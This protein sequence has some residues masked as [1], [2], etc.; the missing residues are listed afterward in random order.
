[1]RVFLVEDSEAVRE[2][3]VENLSDIPGLVFAGFADAEAEAFER[4]SKDSYEIVLFDIELKQGNGI[5]LLRSLFGKPILQ[6]T[7]KII[8]SNNVSEAYRHA[9]KQCGV[10]YFFDKT[11]EL[12]WVAKI[13]VICL[14]FR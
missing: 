3:I 9:G 11:S 2:L 1:M 10:Q 12:S 14:S 8:F 6:N 7:T 5:S 13:V 4:L